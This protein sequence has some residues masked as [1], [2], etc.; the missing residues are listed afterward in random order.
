MVLA[1]I[2]CIDI[3]FC[4]ANTQSKII[5]KLKYLGRDYAWWGV[6]VIIILVLDDQMKKSVCNLVNFI[7]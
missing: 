5:E 1:K 6:I 4:C 3:V 2:E 7:F